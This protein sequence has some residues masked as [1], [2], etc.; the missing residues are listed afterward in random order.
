MA[1][2]RDQGLRGKA[3]LLRGKLVTDMRL[4]LWWQCTELRGQGDLLSHL[5]DRRDDRV[6]LGQNRLLDALFQGVEIRL[7]FLNSGALEA[8][9]IAKNSAQRFGGRIFSKGKVLVD[10]KS[11]G[12]G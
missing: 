9:R 2:G 7:Q 6:A 8:L 4:L 1:Q 5:V 12:S 10:R 11:V 3:G